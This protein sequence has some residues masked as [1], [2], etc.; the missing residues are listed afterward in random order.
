MRL[1]P[2]AALLAPTLATAGPST[3]NNYNLEDTFSN[4]DLF[5]AQRSCFLILVRGVL[6]C[7]QEVVPGLDH[8]FPDEEQVAPYIDYK[9]CLLYGRTGCTPPPL[10]L[11]TRQV[12]VSVDERKLGGLL[13]HFD[14]T[15]PTLALRLLISEAHAVDGQQVYAGEA[16]Y[17]MAAT[18][19]CCLRN[20]AFA[21]W[22]GPIGFSACMAGK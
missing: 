12:Q 3:P 20:C 11:A 15:H 8:G 21:W 14:R 2:I 17:R 6:H 9:Y 22:W 4:T 19:K 10:A 7:D 16:G 18:G 13:E 1:L 5:L